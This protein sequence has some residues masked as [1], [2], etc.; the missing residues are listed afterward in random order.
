M[1]E[2]QKKI[3]TSLPVTEIWN[4]GGIISKKKVKH[5]LI[6][7]INELLHKYPEAEL[8]IADGGHKFYFIKKEDKFNVWKKE[9]KNRIVE[10]NEF[11]LEEFPGEYCYV[12]S[13]WKKD[14]NGLI[15]LFEMHH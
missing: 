9:L 3:I 5:L 11:Y 14:D 2:Y 8:A 15:I 1:I 10:T 4:D 6:S 12:A 7:D 13:L